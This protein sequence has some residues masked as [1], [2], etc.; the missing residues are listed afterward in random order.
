M[1]N[2]KFWV[3][4]LTMVLLISFF[5]IPVHA[6]QRPA[7]GTYTNRDGASV[8]LWFRTNPERWEV[9]IVDRNGRRQGNWVTS[10]FNTDGRSYHIRFRHAGSTIAVSYI[11]GNGLL[12]VQWHPFNLG[13]NMFRRLG[14]PLR[15]W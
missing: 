11:I 10:D 12:S 15:N 9:E 5:A 1:A 3:G 7:D 14:D 2:K 13:T 4:L 6:Q 8:N